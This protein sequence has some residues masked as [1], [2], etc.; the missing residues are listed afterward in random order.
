[1]TALQILIAVYLCEGILR[2][3]YRYLRELT[4]E[5]TEE[6]EYFQRELA[7]NLGADGEKAAQA[8]RHPL[9]ILFVALIV[10]LLWPITSIARTIMA[11]RDL[12]RENGED[13]NEQK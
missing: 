10:G 9:F 5:E 12:M 3:V 2:G 13:E 7:E 1:M 11:A 4:K 8:S 6:R